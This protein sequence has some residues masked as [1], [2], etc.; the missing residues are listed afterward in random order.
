MRT[1]VNIEVDE[2]YREF[3]QT[4]HQ[5][6]KLNMASMMPDV[7]QSE[8]VIMN[9]IRD[10]SSEGKVVISEL[11]CRCKLHSSAVSRTLHGL[12]ERGY[13][14]RHI[15]KDDRRNICVELT[16]EGKRTVEECRQ[17]MQDFGRTVLN[18][19]NVRDMERLIT[20]M[21]RLY[22]VAEKE[23]ETRKWKG[24]KGKEHE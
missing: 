14:E 2:L 17:I 11:A 13:V 7:S 23:I 3:F 20:Y 19:M 15:D 4:I 22:S 6:R 8:F 24:R 5:F 9:V 18:H 1:E 16:E 12:D 21:N 10:K